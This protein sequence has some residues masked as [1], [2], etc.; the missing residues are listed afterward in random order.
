MTLWVPAVVVGPLRVE[1]F[2]LVGITPALA[3]L[4]CAHMVPL[5]LGC[6]GHESVMLPLWLHFQMTLGPPLV[7]GPVAVLMTLWVPAVVVGPLHVE[8]CQLVGLTPSFSHCLCAH[9]VPL[10]LGWGGHGSVMLP[11][12]LHFQ[13][14]IEMASYIC[15][16][17]T[18]LC[19]AVLLLLF[20][21][22]IC[23]NSSNDPWPYL[24][25]IHLDL[26]VPNFF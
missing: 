20:L 11:L 7:V 26:L 24:C 13:L 4:L 21:E 23:C 3:H 15:A 10:V 12:W 17:E 6:G 16:G 2:Q 14:R 22:C 9:M 19:L 1:K 25:T 5:V 18:Q 8:K